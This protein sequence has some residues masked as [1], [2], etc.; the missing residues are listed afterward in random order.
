MVEL[1]DGG[2]GSPPPVQLPTNTSPRRA[3][4]TAT[5]DR[6]VWP[7]RGVTQRLPCGRSE[8][9]KSQIVAPEVR[10]PDELA[11]LPSVA[12]GPR[13]RGRM[14]RMRG[15]C[16]GESR[17]RCFGP[18]NRRRA[19]CGRRGLLSAPPPWPSMTRQPCSRSPCRASLWLL[20]ELAANRCPCGVRLIRA[21]LTRHESTD[22][23]TRRDTHNAGALDGCV[24]HPLPPI[25][26]LGPSARPAAYPSASPT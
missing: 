7:G 17:H 6:R 23:R 16:A 25:G 18:D 14:R 22:R 8:G 19:R 4:N 24:Q 9:R 11:G 26:P 13:R 21:P 5:T 3:T 2:A 12:R 10:L 15:T 1:V 20:G